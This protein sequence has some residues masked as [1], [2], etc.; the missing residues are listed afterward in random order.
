MLAQN[1]YLIL[2]NFACPGLFMLWY[3]SFKD[4][5]SGSGR[6]KTASDRKFH[7]C[8]PEWNADSNVLAYG[9]WKPDTV[10]TF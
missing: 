3:S 2:F 9:L 8:S 6:R 10:R 5:G 1:L 4:F 7:A